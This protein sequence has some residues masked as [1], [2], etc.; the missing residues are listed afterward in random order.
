MTPQLRNYKQKIEK[1]EKLCRAL[2]V[3]RNS[4]TAK[5][6]SDKEL[7]SSP[8]V[9]GLHICKCSEETLNPNCRKC[10]AWRFFG[11]VF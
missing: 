9:V 7:A 6:K 1:L 10:G 4:L 5:D 8:E 3:E 2:Q 11:E